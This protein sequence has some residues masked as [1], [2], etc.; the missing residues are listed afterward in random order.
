MKM[1]HELQALAEGTVKN[2]AASIGE[3]VAA[4]DLLVEIEFAENRKL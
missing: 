3:Q 4:G 1:Q 2:I